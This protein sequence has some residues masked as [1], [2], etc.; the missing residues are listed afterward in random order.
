MYGFKSGTQWQ[1]WALQKREKGS[2]QAS[3]RGRN[4]VGGGREEGRMEE[5]GEG[6]AWVGSVG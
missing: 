2:K 4:V 6:C 3:K 1:I 5:K